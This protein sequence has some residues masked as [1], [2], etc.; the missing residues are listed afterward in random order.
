LDGIPRQRFN[1]ISQ[2]T[3]KLFHL[4]DKEAAEARRL[5]RKY[6]VDSDHVKAANSK[7]PAMEKKLGFDY[8]IVNSKGDDDF[9]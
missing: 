8:H 6:Q 2:R 9:T 5:E 4:S 1:G 7:A 3:I